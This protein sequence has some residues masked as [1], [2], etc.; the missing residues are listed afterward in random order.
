M[1]L[2]PLAIPLMALGTGVAAYGMIQQ[3]QQANAAAKAQASM[4][5]AN[6]RIAE[7]NAML[8]DQATTRQLDQQR[9]QMRRLA[10]SQRS[11]V[12]SSGLML[13]GSAV[14]VMDDSELEARIE[15]SEIHRS[16]FARASGFLQEGS[17]FRA[18]ASMTR[19]AGR[20]ARTSGYM[21]AGG[22]LLTG[23]SKI[24]YMASKQ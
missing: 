4:Q 21:G 18:Q 11:A 3:G 1:F 24:G 13:S 12:A 6:A 22:T 14:D 17:D 9:S 20:N 5:E 8:T 10:G 7:N 16:G 2:A 23:G 15:R 19:S